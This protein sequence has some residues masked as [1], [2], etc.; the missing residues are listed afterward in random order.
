[1]LTSRSREILSTVDTVIVDEIH[2]LVSGKRGAHLFVSLERLEQ[3]REQNAK[4]FRPLQRI[5]L[6]ATQRPL[7]EIARLLGG[8][9]AS[10][11]PNQSHQNRDRVEIVEAGRRKTLELK[12]EVPVEDM[13]RLSEP[14]DQTGPAAAAPSV[15]SIWPS[16]H[17]RLVELIKQH[18][19]TMIF[20]NSRRLAERLAAAINEL[21]DEELAAAHHGSIAKDA[22]LNIEDRLKRG[23]AARDRGHLVAR[24]GNRYGGGRSGDS[25]RG[26][27]V[28][29]VRH[30]TNRSI[31]AP[32]RCAVQGDHL[33][34]VPR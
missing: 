12:I 27:A 8:G 30:S 1:M 33:P 7:D 31:R 14:I 15:P 2:S 19:S 25:D 21:A 3:L 6:S 4:S 17:P 10:A 13:A 22:R 28:H 24:I 16:I 11:N 9:V 23:T 5:G 26:A 32:G 20:V 34:Q 29:C 18:R